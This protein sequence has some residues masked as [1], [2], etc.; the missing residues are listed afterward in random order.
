MTDITIANMNKPKLRRTRKT[1]VREKL[2]RD[3]RGR[4][5]RVMSLDANSETFSDDLEVVFQRNVAKVRRENKR[6][7]GSA[8]GFRTK[9][10]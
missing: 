6:L 2:L 1:S 4:S 5:V 8:S 10:K 9:R 3:S 7:F